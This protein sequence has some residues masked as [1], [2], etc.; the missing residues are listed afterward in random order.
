MAA[1]RKKGYKILAENYRHQKAEIDIID[2]IGNI[3]VIVEVKTR[4]TPDFGLPQEFVKTKQIAQLL[5]AV[6]FY[7]TDNKL[8]EVE[9]RFDIVS[10]I[11]NKKGEELEHIE[12]AF[13]HFQ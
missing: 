7:I 9:A 3:L 4:S 8:H 2:R 12:N 6:D 11:I 5:K 10:V 13:Y 1:L